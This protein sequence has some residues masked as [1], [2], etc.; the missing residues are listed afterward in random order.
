M[1]K[2]ILAYIVTVALVLGLG[3]GLTYLSLLQFGFFAPKFEAVKREVFVNTP[4]F[5]LGKEQELAKYRGEYL[6]GD[7]TKKEIIKSVI[8][9]S[10]AGVNRS[11]L[12]IQSKSFLS[13]LGL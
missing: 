5:I 2:T 10:V 3:F 12:S 9:Q 8:E 13:D 11:Q 6:L 4:S 7:D 1:I